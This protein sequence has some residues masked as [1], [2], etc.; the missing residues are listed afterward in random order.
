MMYN[1][2]LLL[3]K[4]NPGS[5]YDHN[6]DYKSDRKIMHLF[7]SQYLKTQFHL[8]HHQFI[9]TRLS[10]PSISC[11]GGKGETGVTDS[12]PSRGLLRT[13]GTSVFEAI[14]VAGTCLYC[15]KVYWNF[16][17][18]PW[19]PLPEIAPIRRHWTCGRTALESVGSLLL[20]L[21]LY[22]YDKRT[23]HT[24][25]FA[26]VQYWKYPLPGPGR[27]N[28]KQPVKRYYGGGRLLNP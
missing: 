17:R 18:C 27:S 6:R 19:V 8:L 20:T 16:G 5:P 4:V 23:A 14:F 12:S 15:C 24:Y 26:T 1:S 7:S 3:L 10:D 22:L 28:S 2:V 13:C 11:I 9:Y 21:F 25:Q